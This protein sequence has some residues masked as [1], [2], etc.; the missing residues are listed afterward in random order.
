MKVLLLAPLALLAGCTTIPTT[1]P[2][3][4]VVANQTALDEKGAQ[5]V[6]LAYKAAR[7][8][9]E[10]AVDAGLITGED[11][12]IAADLDRRAFATV[13]AV[14]AAYAA[15]NAA[16]YNTAIA[17]ALDAVQAAMAVVKGN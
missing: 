13:A 14:R 7:L 12:R 5:A 15:Q 16:D 2:P 4:V 6:E 9:A 10:T 1:P 17:R 3:P 11:A 8:A